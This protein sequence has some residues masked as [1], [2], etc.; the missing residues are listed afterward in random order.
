MN[1]CHLWANYVQPYLPEKGA[2]W[3]SAFATFS[4]VVVSL[5]IA[6]R[7]ARDRKR[8]A[9][10]FQAE[11]ITAWFKPLNE[12]TE[13]NTE[14]TYILIRNAS[15]QMIYDLILQPVTL[16]GAFRQT[17]VGDTEQRNLEFGARAGNIPPGETETSFQ[18]LDG[19][20]HK[21]FGIELAFKDAAG[22]FWLRQGD[23][24]LKEISQHPLDLYNLSRPIGWQN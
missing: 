15:D 11:K 5:W 24:T 20:M 13:E 23:G 7:D 1:L 16:Q 9:R 22:R 8:E 2:E 4:A 14:R 12:L 19:G 6:G 10:R 18:F 21:R 17:A 3:A